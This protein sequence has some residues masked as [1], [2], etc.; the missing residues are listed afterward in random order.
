MS[1]LSEQ[2]KVRREKLKK[3]IEMGI[4]PYPADLFP[5]TSSS[6]EIK[7]NFKEK[8]NVVIAGRIMSRRIQGNASFAE[9]QDNFGRI[10]LYLNRDEIC[11]GDDKTLYNEVYKKLLDIGDIIGIEG[12]LFKTKVGEKTVL[13]K[14]F[15]ILNK[16][17]RPLPLPKKDAEG[18]VFDEFNDPEQRYRQRYVDLIVN[19]SVKET[20]IKRTKITNSIR[21]FLNDKGYLEVETPILQPIPGGAA[22]R[23]FLTH[24]NAL[25]IPLYMRIANELYLK[26]LIVGGFD[27]VYEFAKDFR[28]EGMDRSH[29]P[30]FT[31]LEFYVAY[32]DYLW[33]MKTTEQLLEKVAIGSNGNTKIKLGKETIEFKAPYPRI[34]ILEA[35]E[36]YTGEDVS[37]MDEDE[38]RECA[39]KM[40]IEVDNTMGYGKLVDEIFGEK[41]EHEFIQPT[42]IIDYPKEMS[43]LTKEHRSNPKL[44]ERFELIVDGKEIANGYSEL[45]DPIDQKNRFEEQLKLSKKGD[46]EAT[47]FIDHDFLRALEYGM[48]PTSGI[49]IGIDRLVMLMTNISSIQE[50]IFFP[51]MKPERKKVELSENEKIIYD[52]LSNQEVLLSEIKD[53]AELSNKAWDKSTKSLRKLGLVIVEKKDDNIYISKSK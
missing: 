37:N 29:N 24:H 53:K 22:A 19:P 26:R 8:T 13:V 6:K 35:I 2:E 43:P 15:T 31:M 5:I 34:P 28:N 33:M 46:L 16:S 32:K 4:N 30:E 45:N 36:K 51:Q 17:I 39:K 1:N 10:Q 27:G 11:I 23:P 52:L 50:V 21:D 41:C 3:L 42:F 20:F 44:T 7:E 38:L 18:N 49:G 14:N 25:N 48:P 47:E 9:I 12:S 40:G